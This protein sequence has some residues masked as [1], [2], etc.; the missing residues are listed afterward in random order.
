MKLLLAILLIGGLTACGL[1]ATHRIKVPSSLPQIKTQNKNGS[2]TNV[3]GKVAGIYTNVNAVA[4]KIADTGITV[5]SGIANV[6][7]SSPSASANV[8]DISSA[9]Q[10]ISQRVESLPGSI[11]QQAKVAYCQQVLLDATASSTK[12]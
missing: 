2:Q 11:A 4:S 9:V 1:L 10:A 5:V 7:T 6:L 3:T 12:K 8:I